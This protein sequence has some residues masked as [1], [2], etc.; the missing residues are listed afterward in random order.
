MRGCHSRI[1]DWGC[2]LRVAGEMTILGRI[3]GMVGGSILSI[4]TIHN[5]S[6][7]WQPHFV[8]A[9]DLRSFFNH[10]SA[11]FVYPFWS[12]IRVVGAKRKLYAVDPL[13]SVTAS[14]VA[15]MDPGWETLEPSLLRILGSGCGH[16]FFLVERTFGSF[17]R[18][19]RYIL[20]RH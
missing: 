7:L 2:H 11:T 20:L 1:K 19:D 10:E 18:I 17:Y 15:S 12:H 8:A 13:L 3:C 4:L 9:Q 14:F 6:V 5:L 16:Q